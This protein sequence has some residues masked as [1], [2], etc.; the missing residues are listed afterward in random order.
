VRPARSST[1]LPHRTVPSATACACVRAHRLSART[2][3]RRRSASMAGSAADSGCRCYLRRP[4][5]SARDCSQRRRRR[6]SHRQR[7]CRRRPS[8]LA[9]RIHRLPGRR[10]RSIRRLCSGLRARIHPLLRWA[11]YTPA[12]RRRRRRRRRPHSLT[13]RSARTGPRTVRLSVSA[14]RCVRARRR[15]CSASTN[16][17]ATR[18]DG[19]SHLRLF[20]LRR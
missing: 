15:S 1:L 11:G 5:I 7:L 20:R 6:P 4:Q 14:A 17:A 16:C 13:V 18:A 2:G 3:R 12:R 8:P 9:S 19:S 10:R